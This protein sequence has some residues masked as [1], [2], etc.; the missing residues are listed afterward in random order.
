MLK[1]IRRNGKERNMLY[2]F[3]LFMLLLNWSENVISSQLMR[4]VQHSHKS[5]L[6][7]KLRKERNGSLHPL[8]STVS[9]HSNPLEVPPS[10]R[11]VWKTFS[12]LHFLD[13][14]HKI[15]KKFSQSNIVNMHENVIIVEFQSTI[16]KFRF[17]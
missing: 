11:Y 15:V 17:R 5:R 7:A 3:L 16:V 8:G 10:K 14:C 4:G 2:H 1:K 9:L 12:L 13:L 6:N